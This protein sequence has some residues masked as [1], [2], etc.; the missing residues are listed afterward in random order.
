MEYTITDSQRQKIIDALRFA[1]DSGNPRAA[2][3]WAKLADYL[4]V[5]EP[6]KRLANS[7]KSGR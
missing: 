6:Q 1:A 3:D 7:D 2:K 5:L 4:E